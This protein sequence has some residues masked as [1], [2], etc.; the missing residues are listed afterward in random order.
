MTYEEILALAKENTIAIKE[1]GKRREQEH[2]E[3]NERFEKEKK[4][5]DKEMAELRKLSKENKEKLKDIAEENRQR[6]ARMEKLSQESK[7]DTENLKLYIE[8]VT[9]ELRGLGVTQG[10]IAEENRQRDARMEKLSQESKQE[11]K[12]LKLYIEGVTKELR[13]LGVTQ[14]DIAE[15]EFYQSLERHKKLGALHFDTIERKVQKNA[16]SPEF[17]ILLING[18]SVGLIEVKANLRTYLKNKYYVKRDG[19]RPKSFDMKQ[20][21]DDKVNDFRDSCPEYK[22][23][24]LYFGF[25]SLVTDDKLIDQAKENGIFLL[26]QK[27]NHIELVN[28]TVRAF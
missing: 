27:G 21:I 19:N 18:D 8:G 23:Y 26:T 25:G 22:D 11:L 7:K 20:C 5:R 12:D 1:M 6:D 2:R 16:S 13:G 3:W 4:E 10:E 17:D 14:G 28:E 9:K 24:K 15:E